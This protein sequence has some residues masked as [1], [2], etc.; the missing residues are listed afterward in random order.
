MNYEPKRKVGD[1]FLYGKSYWKITSLNRNGYYHVIKCSK[2]GKE[3][4][5]TNGFVYQFVDKLP[6]SAFINSD[7]GVKAD[8]DKGVKI[9]QAKLRISFLEDR[10]R[11]DNN[12]LAQL[13]EKLA[14]LED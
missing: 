14:R 1:V 6:E 10:I 13:R 7:V 4:R 3:Y 9:T 11:R 5:D 2:N 8:I 12:E